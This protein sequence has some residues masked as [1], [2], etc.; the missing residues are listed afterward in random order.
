[1]EDRIGVRGSPADYINSPGALSYS[2]QMRWATAEIV[3]G[4]KRLSRK[5]LTIAR[6]WFGYE[7]GLAGDSKMQA[8]A[9]LLKFLPP[10]S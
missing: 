7:E 8:V 4:I 6:N 2:C 9:V 10:N 5:E 1:M 3:S